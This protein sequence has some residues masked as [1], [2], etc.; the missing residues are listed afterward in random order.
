MPGDVRNTWSIGV[1][2]RHGRVW[3]KDIK[4]RE[5]EV[6][7]QYDKDFRCTD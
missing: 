3:E 2:D 7:Y 4:D 5:K 1:S 6:A